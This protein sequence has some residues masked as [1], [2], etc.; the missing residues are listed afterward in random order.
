[1]NIKE[2]IKGFYEKN[3]TGIK[4]AGGL[5]LTGIGAY[6]GY[7]VGYSVKKDGLQEAMKGGYTVCMTDSN[8]IDETL[9]TVITP[10]VEEV[11]LDKNMGT[12][13]LDAEFEIGDGLKKV[14]AIAISGAKEITEEAAE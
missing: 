4:I 10:R 12:W 1:M 11:L 2:K 9:F 13:G 8:P 7:K 14:M 6:I 3:E 5:V